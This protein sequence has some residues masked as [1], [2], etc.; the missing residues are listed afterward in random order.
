MPADNVWLTQRQAVRAALT[1]LLAAMRAALGRAV[2]GAGCGAGTP[3][4]PFPLTLDR[5]SHLAEALTHKAIDAGTRVAWF[6]PRITG[7]PS[8]IARRRTTITPAATPT[9]AIPANWSKVADSPVSAL[10]S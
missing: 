9:T 4:G 10:R 6:H 8:D 1:R 5:I 3:A 2:Q 7:L